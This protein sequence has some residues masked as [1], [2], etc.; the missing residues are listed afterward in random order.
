MRNGFMFYFCRRNRIVLQ[1]DLMACGFESVYDE[2][3]GCVRIFLP[4]FYIL[5]CLILETIIEEVQ[6]GCSTENAP[7]ELRIADSSELCRQFT[8]PFFSTSRL[9]QNMEVRSLHCFQKMPCGVCCTH[10]MN[11]CKFRKGIELCARNQFR[12]IGLDQ[13]RI[14]LRSIRS[15]QL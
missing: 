15:S 6:N 7:T 2:E 9:Y 8:S 10:L 4:L 1:V 11:M 13:H 14:T 3:L 12:S 5:C